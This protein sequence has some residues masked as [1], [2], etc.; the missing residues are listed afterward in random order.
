MPLS[1]ASTTM[2]SSHS[3]IQQ[4]LVPY[5]NA[6]SNHLLYAVQKSL[7]AYNNIPMR[8]GKGPLF[9]GENSSLDITTE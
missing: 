2:S 3:M 5:R 1:N 9:Y 8:S 4:Y 7:I 6:N